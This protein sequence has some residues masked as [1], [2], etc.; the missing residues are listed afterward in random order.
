MFDVACYVGNES[1]M[2]KIVNTRYL[3]SLCSA[4]PY[5]AL[6]M[7]EV[8]T[9]TSIAVFIKTSWIDVDKVKD[10]TTAITGLRP[11]SVNLEWLSSNACVL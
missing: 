2:S 5:L 11:L 4:M 1:G 10:D 7:G 6:M 3:C 9:L 8:K